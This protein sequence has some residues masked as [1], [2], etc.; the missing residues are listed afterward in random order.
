MAVNNHG[1]SEI[2]AC[3]A[4]NGAPFASSQT[5]EPTEKALVHST[6]LSALATQ[7]SSA[8]RAM[9]SIDTTAAEPPAT[10]ARHLRGPPVRESEGKR[11]AVTRRSRRS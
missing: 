3:P 6:V 4:P 2:V 10:A 9:A 1:V 7:T 8:G 5:L 11:V